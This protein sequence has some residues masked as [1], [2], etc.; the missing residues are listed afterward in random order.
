MP[1]TISSDTRET[2]AIQPSVVAIHSNN[3]GLYISDFKQ[4]KQADYELS[5]AFRAG[6]KTNIFKSL[7]QS[8]FRSTQQLSIVNVLTIFG[9]VPK[10][11]TN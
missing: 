11:S 3:L 6:F 9:W 10:Y 2:S 1:S 8:P 4:D 5:F 7:D